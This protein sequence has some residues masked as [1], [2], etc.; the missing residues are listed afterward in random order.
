MRELLGHAKY[1]HA[2]EFYLDAVA[3]EV[4]YVPR[5]E[6][7]KSGMAA[8]VAVLPVVESLL[9]VKGAHELSFE[10]ITFEHS[11]WLRPSTVAG[12][13]ET[14]A[15]DCLTCAGPIPKY[16]FPTACMNHSSTPA[17]LTFIAAHNVS[18][19]DCKFRH[20]GANAIAF[21]G[22]SH[23]NTV[24]RSLFTQLS[25]SAVEIGSRGG[26]GVSTDF[27]NNDN[28]F[29][30]KPFLGYGA[31]DLSN[32][33]SD[34]T[35]HR[36]ALEYRGAPAVLV[37]YSRGT[38]ILH[39][40]IHHVPGVGIATGWGWGWFAFTWQGPTTIDGNHIHHHMQ[41]MGD[42][43][44]IYSLG[45]EGNL[46]LGSSPRF[47]GNFHNVTAILPPS[48]IT[49]NWIHDAGDHQT[50]LSWNDGLGEGS[51]APGGVYT[52][53]GSTNWNISGNVLS[54]VSYWIMS[55]RPGTC[56]IGPVWADHNWFDE[57]SNKTINNA[58]RC[59]LIGDVE[60]PSGGGGGSSSVWPFEAQRVMW[61]AGPR[62]KLSAG[63]SVPSDAHWMEMGWMSYTAPD[64]SLL[65]N[66][67]LATLQL[68]G[69]LS[70]LLDSHAVYG[71]PGL[72]NLQESQWGSRGSPSRSTLPHVLYEEGPHGWVLTADWEAAAAD[73]IATLL[74]LV[75]AGSITGLM[76]GDELVCSGFP[77]ANLSALADTLR[78]GLLPSATA[79]QRFFLYRSLNSSTTRL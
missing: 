68:G 25:A 78:T 13:V 61:Q 9:E 31:Q 76:L 21:R 32:E 40:E 48:T 56:P 59:P 38:R 71:L 57:A 58:S 47:N 53:E 79:H 72:L 70:L 64:V 7:I 41:L 55:C 30:S 19:N 10:G 5:P 44:G 75:K 2:G 8:F 16:T 33:I 51:H 34:C 11:T 54:N 6:E 63:K 17:A 66:K 35:I 37:L 43:G 3:G 45:P 36:V 29:H 14:Q 49:G 69:N 74:P 50:A 28:Y 77:L 1:G 65:P 20:H 26:S 24:S 4:H 12:F 27:T 46:P 18:I 52:D 62:Q 23:G 67:T 60:V 39:N 15:G 73:V 42:G 22:G